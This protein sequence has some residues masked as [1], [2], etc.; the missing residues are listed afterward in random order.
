[1]G[2]P[3]ALPPGSPGLRGSPSCLNYNAL[4]DRIPNTHLLRGVA[5]SL[6]GQVVL[7]AARCTRLILYQVANLPKVC[8]ARLLT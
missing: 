5:S 3:L 2:S 7:S 8:Y 4:K 6:V 1:M